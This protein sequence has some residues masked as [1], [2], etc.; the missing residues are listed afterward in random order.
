MV[1]SCRSLISRDFGPVY[2]LGYRGA[3]HL[4]TLSNWSLGKIICDKN[5]RWG[6][7]SLEELVFLGSW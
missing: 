5:G 1:V 7:C 6:N 3:G 2:H 4:M